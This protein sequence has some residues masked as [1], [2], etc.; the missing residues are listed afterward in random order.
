MSSWHRT[1]L[2]W[3]PFLVWT[4]RT[5]DNTQRDSSVDD[6][7]PLRRDDRWKAGIVQNLSSMKI[8]MYICMY[9]YMLYYIIYILVFP[10]LGLSQ[11]RPLSIE[12]T[13]VTWLSPILGSLVTVTYARI[14]GMW[15]PTVQAWSSWAYRERSICLAKSSLA[16]PDH[17]SLVWKILG[18]LEPR[19]KW[20]KL[21]LKK[22][23]KICW[24]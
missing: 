19:R 21:I 15:A 24:W 12:I 6:G 2:L 8:G 1:H 18:K 3:C 23:A 4:C 20:Q 13:M 17:R 22:Q 7:K 16:G 9:I 5:P 14:Q 11:I 10:T